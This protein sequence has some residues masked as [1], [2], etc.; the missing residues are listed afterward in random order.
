MAGLLN[1]HWAWLDWAPM[2][3]GAKGRGR[4]RKTG[5]SILIAVE[6]WC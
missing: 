5:E 4:L 2:I 6:H 1:R 3:G